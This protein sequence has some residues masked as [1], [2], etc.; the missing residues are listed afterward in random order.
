MT[1]EEREAV[2]RLADLVAMLA[3]GTVHMIGAHA[4]GEIILAADLAKAAMQTEKK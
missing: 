1:K 3:H 2:I 4:A